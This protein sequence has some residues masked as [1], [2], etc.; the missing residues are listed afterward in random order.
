MRKC[1]LWAAALFAVPGFTIPGHASA[2]SVFLGGGGTFPTGDYS[3][4]GD[5]DGAKTGFMAFGGIDFPVNENGLSVFGEGYFG[6]NNH[7]YEGD[8]TNLYGAMAGGL[9]DFNA[10]GPGPYV[11]GQV[12]LMVH[13]YKSDNFPEDEDSETGL[14][15]GVGAGYGFPLGSMSGFVEGRY[16]QGNF[17]DGN[18]TFFAVFAGVSIPLG[19]EG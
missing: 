15:F 4:F 1:A 2:Q 17:D 6:V 9:F 8:K 13:S 16:L 3:D 19:G 10:D 11:F 18:T 12:G 7:D 5:G 14:G